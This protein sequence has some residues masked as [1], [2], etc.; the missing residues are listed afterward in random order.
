MTNKPTTDNLFFELATLIG[1]GISALEA[2]KKIATYYDSLADW[3]Q[4]INSLQRGSRFSQSLAKSNLINR[5]ETELISVAEDSGRVE[6]GL[7]MLAK[8]QQKRKERASRL[9]SK[10]LYPF[11]ILLVGMLISSLL[12]L[13]NGPDN[14]LLSVSTL[15]GIQLLALFWLYRWVIGLI[16]KGAHY[17]L[18]QL[19]RYNKSDWFQLHFDHLLIEVMYWHQQ[20]AI[21]AKTSFNRMTKLF[22]SKP[23]K[24]QL[25][26]ASSLCGQG[27]GLSNAIRQSQLPVSK[28]TIQLLSASEQAGELENTLK[29]RL[30]LIA[31]E[32]D[33]QLNNLTDWLPRI[34]YGFALLYALLAVF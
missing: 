3:S 18:A 11:A 24:R 8:S 16:Q 31:E 4:V 21:D 17:W 20:S 15:L 9:K 19:D 23:I 5:F 26:K 10:L 25:L 6:Q 13:L 33:L 12:R 14:S 34:I 32:A 30:E 1:A 22:E 28:D 2:V 7:Q 29:R 27:I